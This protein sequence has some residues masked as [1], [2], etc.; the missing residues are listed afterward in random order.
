MYLALFPAAIFACF[1]LA[2]QTHSAFKLSILTV[3]DLKMLFSR[4]IMLIISKSVRK[5]TLNVYC[6]VPC[7][8]FSGSPKEHHKLLNIQFKIYWSCKCYFPELC[9]DYLNICRKITRNVPSSVPC[10]DVQ[11]I[12]SGFPKENNQLQKFQFELC[13]ALKCYFPESLC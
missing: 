13:W 1:F 2:L 11:V 3:L 10:C 6:S 12:F 7:K 9:A 5:I 8:I 4:I